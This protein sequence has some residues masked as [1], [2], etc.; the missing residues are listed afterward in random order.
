[1]ELNPIKTENE[2]EIQC[3]GNGQDPLSEN[4]YDFECIGYKYPF[5]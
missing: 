4:G 1:M 3:L 5:Y 2:H